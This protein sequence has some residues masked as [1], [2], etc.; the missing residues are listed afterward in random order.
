MSAGPAWAAVLAMPAARRVLIVCP[1]AVIAYWRRT[2]E[3]E[4][5]SIQ[6]LITIGP[7]GWFTA[8]SRELS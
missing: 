6:A 4:D 2:I 3:A 1:F 8:T 5:R 7:I